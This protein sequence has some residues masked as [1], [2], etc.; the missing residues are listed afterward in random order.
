MEP[1]SLCRAAQGAGRRLR[2]PARCNR[3]TSAGLARP[4]RVKHGAG[5]SSAVTV[6]VIAFLAAGA[7]AAA[8]PVGVR[9]NYRHNDAA[10]LLANWKAASAA[11]IVMLMT[12]K[13]WRGTLRG[14]GSV[15]PRTAGVTVQ[16]HGTLLQ[17]PAAPAGAC[18]RCSKAPLHRLLAGM[19]FTTL[20]AAKHGGAA[21]AG[22]G[23]SLL[24]RR[25][26]SH[27]AGGITSAPPSQRAC[28]H[29]GRERAR[30]A[31]WLAPF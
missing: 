27:S 4:G 18:P 25:K 30:Q 29:P 20:T 19:T 2:L 17:A 1:D 14:R 28:R 22:A 15:R 13:G 26:L 16:R 12:C 7:V 10:Q 8:V 31:R 23:S 24:G 5:S 3:K 11:G 9:G 6:M 21:G